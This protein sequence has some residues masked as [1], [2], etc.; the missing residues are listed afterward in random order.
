MKWA[1][2]YNTSYKFILP[3]VSKYMSIHVNHNKDVLKIDTKINNSFY[4]TFIAHYNSTLHAFYKPAFKKIKF[5][6]KGYY[7]YKNIRNTIAPQFGYSHRIYI[8]SYFNH[9]KFIGKTKIIVFGLIKAD[10]IKA[11]L[12]LKSKRPINIFTGRGVRFARQI[13]YKKQGKVSSY[14]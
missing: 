11:S 7:I 6:G 8:Y 1:I 9:V 2:A 5:R 13:V 4:P 10:L 14:R 3:L 12:N